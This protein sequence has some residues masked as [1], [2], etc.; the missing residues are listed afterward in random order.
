MPI[1]QASSEY[2]GGVVNQHPSHP[3]AS[4][5]NN[6]YTFKVGVSEDRNRKCRR[7]MEDSHAFVY[8]YGGV[9]VILT[10]HPLLMDSNAEAGADSIGPG[11]LCSLRRT[12]R[13]ARCRVVWSTLPQGQL[14]PSDPSPQLTLMASST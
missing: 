5:D 3:S 14:N 13:Q 6:K 2:A 9:K 4:D 1:T 12:R 8:D 7:T 10:S 11:L